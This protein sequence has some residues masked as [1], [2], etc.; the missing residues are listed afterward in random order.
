MSTIAPSAGTLAAEALFPSAHAAA[1]FAYRFSTQQYGKSAM[2]ILMAGPT[3]TGKGLG[4]IDGAAQAGMIRRL[5]S[6]LGPLHESIIMAR[7]LPRTLSCA[8][9]SVC[10]SGVAPNLE[11]RAAVRRIADIALTHTPACLSSMQLR[12]GVVGKHFGEPVE[13]GALADRCMVHRNT[14]SKH[15]GLILRWLRGHPARHGR[16]AE[17]GEEDQAQQ[18]L[19]DALAAAGLIT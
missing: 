3:S 2:A 5:V 16:P 13:L 14:A 4:G 19:A 7:F 11:W 1:T 8:C 9:G 18:R 6:G 10:C 12:M 15:A 17:V